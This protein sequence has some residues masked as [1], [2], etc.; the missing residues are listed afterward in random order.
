[1]KQ[2]SSHQQQQCCML[3][4]VSEF[5]IRLAPGV[6]STFP[7][8]LKLALIWICSTYIPTYVVT[9]AGQ[10]C[11]VQREGDRWR[12]FKAYAHKYIVHTV[13]F[14]N[15]ELAFKAFAWRSVLMN[16]SKELI[17]KKCERATLSKLVECCPSYFDGIWCL[18][19]GCT[20]YQNRKNV[21][22]E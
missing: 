22:N 12:Y 20:W 15:S 18:A 9:R 17:T 19:Q 6:H 1:M 11:S 13:H 14:I 4:Y 16:C 8:N 10:I 7:T 2:N 5:I 21:P 3:L